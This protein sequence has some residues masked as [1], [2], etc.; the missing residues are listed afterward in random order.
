MPTPISPEGSSSKKT[1]RLILGDQLNLLHSWFGEA[2]E[3]SEYV[4]MEV[5]AEAQYVRHHIQKVVAFFLAMR[6][7]NEQLLAKGF[8]VRYITLDDPD[9]RHSI[10]ENII[11]L[12]SSGRYSAFEY[13][14]PD[15]YRVKAN[16]EQIATKVAVPVSTVPSEHFL[17]GTDHFKEVYRGHKRYTMEIFYRTVRAK[18]RFLMEGDKPLGGRWN[19]DAQNRNRLKKGVTPPHPLIFRRDVSELVDLIKREGIVTIGTIDQDNFTWPATREDALKLLNYFCSHLLPYFGEYQDA[20]HT[21]Y[22][23][24]FHSRL[25]FSLNIKQL[26]PLEVINAALA[27]FEK[28][29]GAITLPQIEGFIRQIAGWREFIRGIYWSE[30]PRYQ[31]LNALEATRPLPH[32]FWDGETKMNCVRHAVKQ[33]LED[34]YAHHIQRL[35]VTGNFA[36]MAGIDP[37]EVDAW[38]LGIYVDAIEWV[39]LPNT[40]GMSQFADGGIVGTKPYHSSA[41]YINKMSNYCTGCS[42]NYRE[43]IG[44]S[45]CPFNSL[46]W[47]LL[48]RHEDK[49]SHNPRIGMGY[50]L[51]K[52]MSAEGRQEIVA[53]ARRILDGI[54]EL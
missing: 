5:R 51:L 9:N 18:Y 15:E 13:Q 31:T 10:E 28:Q 41:Q 33:S 26:S 3:R 38:Y 2:P 4:I 37:S 12:L 45:A 40:R 43:R 23:Y 42:Y 16:L 19:F 6:A 48:I 50:Q 29:N 20:M 24:L 17:V 22:R 53:Q 49:L 47:D 30:M 34:G 21:D 7:F 44:E 1:L 46:Y 32:Y 8:N 52:K 25:S 27:E 39:Q 11:G 14:E 54:E 36:L 35:M